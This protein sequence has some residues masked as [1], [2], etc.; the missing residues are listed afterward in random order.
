MD[1]YQGVV[2][3][4][5][6]ADRSVFLNTE[7]YIQLEPSNKSQKG[8][9]WY[10]DIVAV[11]LRE[12]SVYLC[13]VTYATTLQKLMERLAAWDACWPQLRKALQRDCSIP[14]TWDIRPW[15]FIPEDRRATF[16]AKHRPKQMPKPKITYLE[17]VVPWKYSSDSRKHDAIANDV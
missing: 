4:F 12:S 1:Y 7:C 5:L 9:S 11:N 16:E 15:I 10:C 6:D 17:S 8:I 3:Q 14:E 2:T 13:E